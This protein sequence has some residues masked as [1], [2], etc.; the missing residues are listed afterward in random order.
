MVGLFPIVVSTPITHMKSETAL[1]ATRALIIDRLNQ[2]TENIAFAK[3]AMSLAVI[4]KGVGSKAFKFWEGEEARHLD[5][6]VALRMELR[7]VDYEI[8]G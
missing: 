4:N 7:D 2:T 8:N 6:W 5:T 1:R 3:Q